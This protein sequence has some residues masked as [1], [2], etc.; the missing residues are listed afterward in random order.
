[1]SRLFHTTVAGRTYPMR[2]IMAYGAGPRLGYYSN[3]NVQVWGSPTGI[4][5]S[6]NNAYTISKTAPMVGAYLTEIIH[7]KKLGPNARSRITFL[8]GTAT[9]VGLRQQ[10]RSIRFNFFGD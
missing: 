4:S 1:M 5:N 10:R 3:P 9:R 7:T 6:A 2:T 8:P